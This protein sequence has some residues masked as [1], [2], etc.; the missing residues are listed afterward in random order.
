M[1]K[2][3][4][5]IT[6]EIGG[7]TQPLEKALADVNKKSRDLQGELKSVDRLLKLDPSNTELLAQ[8]QKLL[9]EQVENSKQKLDHLRAS[10]EQVDEAFKKG[11]IGEEQYR[12]FSR[13]V[14]NAE[15]DLKKFEEQLKAVGGTAKSTGLDLNDLGEKMDSAGQKMTVGITA[16]VVAAGG[17][18]L[19]GAMDAEAA[20][21]KLQASLGLTAEEAERLGDIA[22]DVWASGFGESI[23]E[24]NQ[25]IV[26]IRQNMAGLSDEEL[27]KATEGAM[28]I[29]NVFGED[30]NAVAAAAGVAMKNFGI[31]GQEALDIITVGFQRG[32]NYSG[33][34]LDTIREYSPQFASLGLTAD[35]AMGMLI[36]GAQA[37]AWNLD[38]VGDAMKEFNVR[39]QDGSTT[40]AEGFAAI[41][42][43]AQ[44]MGKDIAAGGE[45]AQQAFLATITA[46]S[47]M[48]DPV[49]QNA[50]GVALFGTQWE[51][52]RS[53]VVAAM[54]DGAKGIE[55]FQG[56]TEEA[57]KAANENNPG[58]A[59]TS[60]MREVQ[61]SVGP[62]LLPIADIITNTVVPAIKKMAEWFANLSPTGQKFT[63]SMV[64][65]AA[66]IGPMLVAVG[67]AIKILSDLDLSFIKSA[68]QAIA[69]AAK[70]VASWLTMGVQAGIQAAKV[71][72]G[73]VLMGVQ[74]LL[75]AAKMAAAWVIAMGPIAW[76]T[77]A[78]IALVALIVAN[79]ETVSAK[80]AEIWTAITNGL[81]AAWESIKTGIVNV[82]TSITS[83]VGNAVNNLYT[84]IKNKME[85]TWAYI[86]SIPSQAWNWGKDIIQR[87]VD[88]FKSINI[89]TP[90]FTVGWETK[91]FAGKS[92]DIPDFNVKWYGKG[93]IFTRPSIIGIGEAGREAAVPIDRLPDFIA[94]ALRK[95][96]GEQIGGA[97]SAGDVNVTIY[98]TLD[99][100]VIAKSTSRVQ[101]KSN[102]AKS[103]ALGVVTS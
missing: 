40:T 44:K 74:S 16:P 18:M 65:I 15:Q 80:T 19:K 28:T 81:S 91:T 4:K 89:P 12:H 14:I 30:V 102:K 21:G 41:G 77:A 87:L 84:T 94:D 26:T 59:I 11:D 34:L 5:G 58:R 97:A 22:T 6:I 10:Q 20:Q 33:E 25:A 27:Q 95:V 64:G 82:W 3:I 46:L 38:K 78:V 43:D 76:V 69:N 47:A 63:L 31:S 55:D 53:K 79:W 52:L 99:G 88:G 70:V 83:S 29:A 32:G 24:A 45:Q 71:V 8:K 86:K 60:A 23:D 42:L 13:Q 103:R 72:A 2:T 54:A 73:W 7:N 39:A 85:D 51:D 1:A 101:A 17:I 36:A 37:G 96:A 90:H 61:A 48:E 35:Q 50:A 57:A 98:T 92:V 66:A 68:A 62:A 93:A 56:A 49:A 75:N 9:A 67:K 100:K